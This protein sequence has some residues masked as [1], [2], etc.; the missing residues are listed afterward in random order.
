VVDR[1]FGA[2]MRQLRTERGLSFRALAARTL[3][4]KSRLAEYESGR[5]LPP[6][7]VAGRI[8][9]ALGAGG[10]LVALLSGARR[11]IMLSEG[12]EFSASW[13]RAVEVAAGLWRGDAEGRNL[14]RSAG[15]RADAFMMP[16]MRALTP[17][18]EHPVGSGSRPVETP[19]V[20]TVRRTT[21]T[22][23]ALDNEFGGGAIR[24]VAVRFLDSDVAPLLQCGLFDEPVGRALLS[25]TAE[26]TRVAGWA[27][28]DVGMQGLAQRY[29]IQA[30]RLA[31]GAA[32]LPLAAEVLAAMSHQ[33][34]FLGTAAEAV[35]L[36][37]AAGRLA[38]DAGIPALAA[39][40][41]VSEAHGHA[42]AR[43]EGACAVALDRAEKALDRA[44]RSRDPAWIGYFDE[45]YLAARFGH[46]FTALGRGDVAER[47]ARRSLDMDERY[48]RG[49]QFNLALTANALLGQRSPQVDEAAVIGI[50]AVEMAEG[51]RSARSVDRIRQLADRL[52]PYCG[53]AEVDDF[54]ERAQPLLAG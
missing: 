54:T 10:R 22:L 46:C 34:A 28:Y 49:M 9:A 37:R 20:E 3:S 25:A 40:A 45:S 42:V 14:L 13:P 15:F 51:L 48:V 24:E 39:E 53:V 36:A 29:L 5:S 4:S 16:A 8:D 31:M 23:R 27:A 19:D 52:A 32:D 38:G 30:L 11:T 26:L 2:L 17:A 41:A 35:D 47:F 6:D 18:E 50:R 12:L 21:A 7:D 44:D 43:D 33:A 1:Q